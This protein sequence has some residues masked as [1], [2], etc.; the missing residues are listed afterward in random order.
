[1]LDSVALGSLAETASNKSAK[2]AHPPVMGVPR[3][4]VYLC[5]VI[6]FINYCDSEILAPI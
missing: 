3:Y 2:A 5:A 4:V 1:M 6:M